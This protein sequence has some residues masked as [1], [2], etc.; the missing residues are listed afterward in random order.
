MFHRFLIGCAIALFSSSI[1]IAQDLQPIA[2]PESRLRAPDAKP[3][4]QPLPVVV[5]LLDD[6]RDLNGSLLDTNDLEV[7][8]AFGI[9][10]MPL[11]EVL[12]IRMAR[13]ETELTTIVLHN[14]DIITGK[15]DIQNLL[16]QTS[17]GKSEVNGNNLGSIFF[18]EGLSWKGLKLL[19]GEKWTLEKAEELAPSPTAQASAAAPKTNAPRAAQSV[20]VS[21]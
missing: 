4:V 15:V 12:G 19:A 8:T 7:K 13:D 2:E 16:V 10:K 3:Q 17:W 20:L 5:E 6:V 14:G 18:D 9:A 21:P 1:S 11:T